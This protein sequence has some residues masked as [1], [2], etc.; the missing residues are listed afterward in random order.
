VGEAIV[1]VSQPRA[2]CWKLARRWNMPQL[3]AHVQ[4]IGY[5]G[6]YVR[7]LEAGFVEAGVQ[8][9]LLE[10]SYPDWTV[11]RASYVLHNVNEDIDSAAELATVPPLAMSWKK[12]LNVR[13]ARA[14]SQ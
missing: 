9:E 11:A 10:R 6:W 5:T 7:V 14:R 8:V 3:A 4:Q 2:P 12:T 1:E 13:V